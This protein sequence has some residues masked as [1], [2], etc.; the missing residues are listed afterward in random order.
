VQAPE[1]D[2]VIHVGGFSDQVFEVLRAVAEGG[3]AADLWV[4]RIDKIAV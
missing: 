2:D 3:L 1:G 4:D